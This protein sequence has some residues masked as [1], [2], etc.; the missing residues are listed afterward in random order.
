MA[1]PHFAPSALP[2][3]LASLLARLSPIALAFSG[4][5]DSRFLAHAVRLAAAD[6][7]GAEV[8]LFHATGPHVPVAESADARAWAVANGFGFTVVPVDPLSLPEVRANAKDRCYHCKRLLFARLGEAASEHFPDRATLCD[9]SNASDLLLFRPGLKAIEELG[10]RSP[11]AEAALDKASIRA[12]AAA[13][14][15]DNPEQ[16]A[17]PCMLTRFAYGLAPSYEALVAAAEA[18][19][20][21]AILLRSLFPPPIPDFRLRMV[22]TSDTPGS[23]LPYTTELHLAARPDEANACRLKEA[24]AEQGFALP[25]IVVLDAVSGHFDRHEGAKNKV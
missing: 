7:S 8:H 16:S 24:V 14:K 11:L 13:T 25:L 23:I 1:V 22:G 17:R 18:E 19:R 6:G 10:V 12:I 2:K 3:A 21:I 4:G 5:L 20:S 9:G 15:L